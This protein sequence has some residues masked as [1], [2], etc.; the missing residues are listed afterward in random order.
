LCYAQSINLL[1]RC[2]T[3]AQDDPRMAIAGP[4]KNAVEMPFEVISE[5]WSVY[6]T[7]DRA[8]I[9]LKLVLLKLFLTRL[10]EAGNANFGAATNVILT[11]SVPPNMKGR[12]SD[13][14]ISP[15]EV[16]ESIVQSDIPFK[17]VRE[18]WNEYKIDDATV[19]V[20]LIATV[21]SKSSKFDM[22]GDPIYN[23]QHQSIVKGNVSP[24]SRKKLLKMLREKLAK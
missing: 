2:I 21:I 4:P 20:K 22:N 6:E 3:L 17:T 7:K 10:D 1:N 8:M 14:P 12:R 15:K 5:G 19:S 23:V 18:D 11:V 9:K 24:K 13:R 16:A